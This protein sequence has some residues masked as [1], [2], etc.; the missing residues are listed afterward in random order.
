MDIKDIK[1]T[2]YDEDEFSREL[3]FDLIAYFKTLEEEIRNV[4]DDNLTPIEAINKIKK[5]ME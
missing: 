4:L 1:I 5:V 3:E 2:A